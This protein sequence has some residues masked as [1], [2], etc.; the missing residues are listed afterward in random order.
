MLFNQSRQGKYFI[1]GRGAEQYFKNL[2]RFRILKN[3]QKLCNIYLTMLLM[4]AR[5]ASTQQQSADHI[6]KYKSVWS[7]GRVISHLIID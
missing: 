1:D 4:A 3:V 5:K 6:T 7:G 2:W